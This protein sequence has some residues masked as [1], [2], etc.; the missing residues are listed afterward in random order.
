MTLSIISFDRK[1]IVNITKII[2]KFCIYYIE[3]KP[4]WLGSR[5]RDLK[6]FWYKTE[7]IYFV[8]LC[9]LCV[10]VWFTLTLNFWY[11]KLKNG[12][13]F[14][15]GW[16]LIFLSYVIM[17]DICI[18]FIEINFCFGCM[19]WPWFFGCSKIEHLSILM[20][21]WFKSQTLK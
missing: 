12:L 18:K 15:W 3:I 9:W 16:R 2:F 8:W 14:F 21:Y 1:S 4:F 13:I 17:Q 6:A 20:R 19:V 11:L 5:I 10:I 7:I